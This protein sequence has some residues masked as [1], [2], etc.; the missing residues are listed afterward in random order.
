METEGQK[1]VPDVVLP[2]KGARDVKAMTFDIRN[3][4]LYW[5]DYGSRR[6]D[7]VSI[8]KSA[9]D[10]TLL[11]RLV[12]ESDRDDIDDYDDSMSFEPFGLAFDPSSDTLFWTSFAS[13]MATRILENKDVVSLGAVLTTKDEDDFRPRNITVHN[14][15]G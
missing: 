8:K 9:E 15:K 12:L 1:D 4:M 13:I 14:K 6:T 11:G 5:I 3:R 2:I 7:R 10:G